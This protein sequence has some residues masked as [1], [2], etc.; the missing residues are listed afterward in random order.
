MLIIDNKR[1]CS[2]AYLLACKYARCHATLCR[3]SS[4]SFS[5]SLRRDVLKYDM[6]RLCTRLRSKRMSR[7]Y[8]GRVLLSAHKSTSSISCTTRLSSATSLRTASL[9]ATLLTNSRSD[10]SCSHWS[11][12]GLSSGSWYFW[13]SCANLSCSIVHLVTL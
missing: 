6:T 13:R 4:I 2:H 1:W 9:S 12:C 5:K 3:F 11:S 10:I 7:S 8:A